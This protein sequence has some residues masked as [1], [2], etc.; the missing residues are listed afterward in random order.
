MLFVEGYLVIWT[1]NTLWIY[2]A[3]W[4]VDTLSIYNARWAVDTLRIYNTSLFICPPLYASQITLFLM[5]N[6][7]KYIICYYHLYYIYTID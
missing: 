1:F 2:N 3:R 7:N 5:L 6:N 4:T